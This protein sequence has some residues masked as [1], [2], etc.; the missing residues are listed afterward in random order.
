MITDI[1]VGQ[2]LATLNPDGVTLLVRVAWN[3][4]LPL[5]PYVIRSLKSSHALFF[6]FRPPF[7]CI[8]GCYLFIA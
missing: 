3:I 5:I 4:T 8:M 7:L 2:W 1:S 6:Y